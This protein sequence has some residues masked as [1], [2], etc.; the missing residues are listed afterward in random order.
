MSITEELSF[1]TLID[2]YA[3][4]HNK[5]RHYNLEG[6]IREACGKRHCWENV[7]SITLMQFRHI[8]EVRVS[9]KWEKVIISLVI[10]NRK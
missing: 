7:F 1:R 2:E 3:A 6:F 10:R 8:H 4:S 9:V 5:V